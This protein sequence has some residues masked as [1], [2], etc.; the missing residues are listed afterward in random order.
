MIGEAHIML[1]RFHQRGIFWEG[2][3]PARGEEVLVSRTV[4]DP[5]AGSGVS[6]EDALYSWNSDSASGTQ[7]AAVKRGAFKRWA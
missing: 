2:A 3:A 1:E 6:F 5:V 4:K 7:S